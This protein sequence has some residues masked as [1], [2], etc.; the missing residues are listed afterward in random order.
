MRFHKTNPK[1]YLNFLR[2]KYEAWSGEVQVQSSPYIMGID[3]TS[4]CQLRCPICPTGIENE[5]RRIGEKISLR[6]R[7][8]LEVDLFESLVDEVG[9]NLFY[10]MFYNWGEPLLNKQLPVYLRKAKS[11]QICTEIH[12]NLSL[13]ISDEFM[14][15]ILTSGVDIIAA[16]IDGFSSESYQKY[17]RGGNFE[18]CKQNITRLATMRDHLGLHTDIIWNFLVFSFNE[19]E[20]DLAREYC[21]QNGI[22]FNRREAFVVDPE[23]LPSYRRE[24]AHTTKGA[25]LS[26]QPDQEEK[27]VKS[28]AP[29]AWHYNY[30]VVNADGSVSPCCAPWEQAHDFGRVQP[31]LI[32]FNEIWNNTMFQ[33][34]R[35]VFANKTDE[36]LEDVDT[37]CM[38]C[39][40]DSDIQNLYSYL[41]D[42]VEKQFFS[43]V[44]QNDLLLE[45]AFSLL[46]DRPKFMQFYREYLLDRDP[47]QNVQ[48]SALEKIR[49]IAQR[50]VY[51]VQTR[52]TVVRQGIR[53]RLKPPYGRVVRKFPIVSKLA[54]PFKRVI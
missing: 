39:P 13:R 28:S 7:T 23:W 17:R 36:R 19:H 10:I 54:R 51:R 27:R 31:G 26:D 52:A 25:D 35:A 24:E 44:S 21:D 45:H 15:E 43:E 4:I 32:S 18:L 33:K 42:E 11:F 3:P 6:N 9:E 46:K 2:S 47:A 5:K 41:D 40:Y 1:A 34:S 14:H 12:S 30:S 16:S 37:L 48:L 53:N 38:H 8:M 29:C 49:L 20:I 50:D 22:I